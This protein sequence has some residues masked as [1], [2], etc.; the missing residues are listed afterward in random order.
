[1]TNANAKPPARMSSV[2]TLTRYA[3]DGIDAAQW[4]RHGTAQINFVAH[5]NG[6]DPDYFAG[7]IAATSP[8]CSVV[9]NIRLA[10]HYCHHRDIRVIPMRG[11][12]SAVVHFERTG[13]LRGPK[14]SAFYANLRGNPE[15]VTL[16]VWMAYALRVDQSAFSRVATRQR[17][18]ARVA[19]AG[20]ALGLRPCESQAAIWAAYRRAAG[21][22]DSP[23]SV[24]AEYL[25]ARG[26]GWD[27]EGCSLTTHEGD[28]E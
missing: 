24:V 12:R 21:E 13:R 5:A 26:R 1:M 8:R 16:D 23:L 9:R 27:I 2:R 28:T 3:A 7:I 6:W 20:R 14:T 22:R 4:Y 25:A 10:L 18:A 11:V 19:A 15:P 17:A